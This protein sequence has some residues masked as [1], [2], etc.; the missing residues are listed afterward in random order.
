M[1]TLAST[2]YRKYSYRDAYLCIPA[3]ET[4]RPHNDS[5]FL[6][7]AGTTVAAGQEIEVGFRARGLSLIISDRLLFL[8]DDSSL[9]AAAARGKQDGREVATCRSLPPWTNSPACPEGWKPWIQVYASGSY[10]ERM[11]S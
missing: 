2:V 10:R 6:A 3:N 9:P 7:R 5:L 11:G 8:Q 1:A 4:L